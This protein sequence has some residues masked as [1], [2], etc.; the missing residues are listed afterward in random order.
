MVFGGIFGIVVKCTLADHVGFEFASR[1]RHRLMQ[2][3]AAILLISLVLNVTVLVTNLMEDM[4]VANSMPL[5]TLFQE[6][7][8]YMG[9]DGVQVPF[10]SH[11]H[12]PDWYGFLNF[13]VVCVMYYVTGATSAC[14]SYTLMDTFDRVMMTGLGS[15]WI[16][17][18][19]N[20][21]CAL[22]NT[23]PM[24]RY[25]TTTSN[26]DWMASGMA[27][28]FPYAPTAPYVQPGGGCVDALQLGGTFTYGAFNGANLTCYVAP[29]RGVSYATPLSPNPLGKLTE[30]VGCYP[31]RPECKAMP[32]ADLGFALHDSQLRPP[33]WGVCAIAAF[34]TQILLIASVA[35]GAAKVGAS[36]LPTL[37]TL[38]TLPRP[39]PRPYPFYPPYPPNPPNP[40]TGSVD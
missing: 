18:S 36:T 20:T 29:S 21:L 12:S 17:P 13:K 37:S 40:L 38:S 4:G 5:V 2:V 25:G 28:L 15:A 16:E 23:Y 31:P 34:S 6:K 33:I 32:C 3:Q 35:L 8:W 19:T 11:A 7:S 24:S 9:S 26:G 14:R 22:G 10:A 1:N 30:Y 39:H 27:A